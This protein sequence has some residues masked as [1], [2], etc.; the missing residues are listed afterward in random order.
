MATTAARTTVDWPPSRATRSVSAAACMPFSRMRRSSAVRSSMSP[1]RAS[2][3]NAT[4]RASA[5]GSS[6][7]EPK[8]CADSVAVFAAIALS[9]AFWSAS[10]AECSASA[11][12]SRRA[13]SSDAIACRSSG[14]VAASVGVI[15]KS[16]RTSSSF[17][18]FTRADSESSTIDAGRPSM[19]SSK[20]PCSA[21]SAAECVIIAPER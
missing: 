4:C 6:D 3:R 13:S 21:G 16:K 17:A 10:R 8:S 12:P 1:L 5:S 15:L 9:S 7:F 18:P 2:L 14:L 19:R 11:S 20:V